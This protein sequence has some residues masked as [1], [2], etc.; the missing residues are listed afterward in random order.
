MKIVKRMLKHSQGR[1]FEGSVVLIPETIDDLWY[2]YRII[3]PGDFV[4]AKTY[5]TYKPTE[6]SKQERKPVTITIDVE[7]KEFSEYHRSLRL[8]GRIVDGYPSEFVQMGS[9]HTLELKP[10]LTVTVSKRWLNTHLSML[11][12]ASKRSEVSDILIVVVDEEKALFAEVKPRGVSYGSELYSGLSK[13]EPHYEERLQKF[14]TEIIDKVKEFDGPIVIAGPGF[15]KDMVKNKIMEEYPELSERVVFESCSHAER[16]GI[17]ELINRG[18]L[19][20]VIGKTTLKRDREVLEEFKTHLGKETGYVVYGLEPV[21]KALEYHAL[22][23]LVVL[24][25]LLSDVRIREL[26]AKAED[27]H[28]EVTFVSNESDVAEELKGFSGVI[29]FL[30]Y[31]LSLD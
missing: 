17:V 18:V 31:P 25:S 21:S 7:K 22:K 10:H 5:R 23:R 1:R 2:L 14:V 28:V 16:N 15:V 27:N 12:E 6:S 30:Y 26:I 4:K 20:R 9:Y 13:R 19:D 24:D 29:G 11:D 3:E 8:T